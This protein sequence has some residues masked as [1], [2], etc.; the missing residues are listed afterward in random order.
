MFYAGGDPPFPAA[1]EHGNEPFGT[2]L[3]K[4]GEIVFNN[5]FW[6]PQVTEGVVREDALAVLK[7]YFARNKKG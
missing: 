3:V 2:V 1:V 5:S 4:D 6:Q 7:E